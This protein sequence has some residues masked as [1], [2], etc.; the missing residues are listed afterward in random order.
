[1]LCGFGLIGFGGEAA[2]EG[3]F[4]KRVFL[5]AKNFIGPTNQECSFFDG[6]IK[7]MGEGYDGVGWLRCL[8]NDIWNDSKIIYDTAKLS[9]SQVSLHTFFF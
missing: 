5:W 6:S 4:E 8:K 1:M 2:V 3:V 7:R 9:V